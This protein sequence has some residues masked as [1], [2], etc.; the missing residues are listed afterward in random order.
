MTS[1]WL[2]YGVRPSVSTCSITISWLFWPVSIIV[3]SNHIHLHTFWL[4]LSAPKALRGFSHLFNMS[5]ITIPFLHI[6]FDSRSFHLWGIVRERL[7]HLCVSHSEHCKQLIGVAKRPVCDVT[8]CYA[9]QSRVLRKSSLC[10]CLSSEEHLCRFVQAVRFESVLSYSYAPEVFF[11]HSICFTC[12][13]FVLL[14]CYLSDCSRLSGRCV[15]SL[16]IS[17]LQ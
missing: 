3:S 10:F 12:I 5:A 16:V 6:V 1:P 9:R 11:Q 4:P 15:C 14:A 17:C 8:L 2:A 7:N 13:Q